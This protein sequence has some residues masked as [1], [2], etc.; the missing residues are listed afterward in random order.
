[1]SSERDKDPES[2]ETPRILKMVVVRDD[3]ACSRRAFVRNAV[4]GTVAA[5]AAVGACA[6]ATFEIEVDKAG[7]C[8]CHAVCTC[9]PEAEEGRKMSAQ[10]TPDGVCTCNT[11]C[12]CDTVCNCES[13]GGSGGSGG[14]GGGGG[15]YWYP[16]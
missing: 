7:N 5:G 15:Y 6:D 16:N 13:V 4:I 10:Y 3:D 2:A 12:T 11:V 8:R 14:G 1:M 9:D